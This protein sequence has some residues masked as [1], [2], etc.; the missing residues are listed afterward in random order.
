MGK[1][2]CHSSQNSGGTSELKVANKTSFCLLNKTSIY[3]IWPNP[4]DSC[5]DFALIF[6]RFMAFSGVYAINCY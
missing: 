2:C 1:F 6:S 4:D 5:F 3:S